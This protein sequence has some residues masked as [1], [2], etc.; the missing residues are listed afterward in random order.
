MNRFGMSRRTFLKR[1]AAGAAAPYVITSAALGAGDRPPASG[2]V[3]L[4][5]IGVGGQG[6]GL[7]RGFLGL[8]EGQSVA[9]CDPIQKR[10]DERA[11]QIDKHYGS[12]GCKAYTDFREVLARQDID[13][14]VIATPDH[15][16]VPIALAAVRAGKDVYVE[17]PLGISVAHDQALREAVHRYGAIFQYGTQQRS[18]NTHCGFA[19]EL[20]R[21][22][23][24]GELKAIHVVAP[25][26]A[27][28][29]DPTPQPVPEGL[30]YDLW[31]GPAPV[32]P[33]THDRVFGVGRW[34]IYDY[35]IGFI[36]GWGAHPLDIAHW[37]YP[38]VPVEVQGTGVIP[39]KGLFDT[40]VHWDVRGRYASGVEF[41][42]KAGG[43]KTTFVG[44][45][46]WVAPS[47]GGIQAEP[48]SL[49]KVAIRPDEVHLLQ[50]KHHYQNF[51]K[52]VLARRTP[53][54]DIDS[55]VQSDIMSHL[56][57]IAIRTGRTI[58]WDPAKETIVG[59]D[60]AAR[61]LTRDLRAPWRL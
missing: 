26:G 58:R 27:T 57:D 36:A 31:L 53:A 25:D 12:A 51:L 32:A 29:G 23:Y 5:H 20:V 38:H 2:R 59:D 49:L 10:R 55:A 43:D 22:G 11:A 56:G 37:G 33:Y 44:T 42:L 61:M 46:G 30:D 52:A 16:H 14:V 28:G 50:D 47:R 17:K 9:V 19:C 15:W 34:H 1:A 40:V 13:A 48:A 60:E 21:N 45:E 3:V 41:T 39:T 24:I 4:G 54:S 6:S 35:A 18:F 7:L 8:A